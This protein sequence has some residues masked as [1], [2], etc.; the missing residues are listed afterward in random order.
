MRNVAIAAATCWLVALPCVALADRVAGEEKAD[1]CLLCHGALAS[2]GK[3]YIPVLDGQPPAYFIAQLT[4]YQTG[5]RTDATMKTNAASLSAVD[6]QDLADFF[7]SRKS[8]P[9]PV[10]DS[11]RA[12]SGMKALAQLPC[13][14]CHGTDYS[15]NGPVARLAGQNPRYM[16]YE[17]RSMRSG[18]RSH[19]TSADGDAVK[20]L[21]DDDVNNVA[22]AFASLN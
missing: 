17:L 5:K 2:E 3:N 1:L 7:A 19:S 12:G 8:G 13:R 9:Y 4:A 18:R 16:A 10:F 15:G 6:A 14:S 21:T 22:H 11:E 20:T